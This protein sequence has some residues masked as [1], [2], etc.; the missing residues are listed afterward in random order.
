MK[1]Y[2]V[3]ETEGRIPRICLTSVKPAPEE[4]VNILAEL[5]VW[6]MKGDANVVRDIFESGICQ[7]WWW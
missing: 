6:I 7:E 5:D 1:V 2:V 3:E 4:P